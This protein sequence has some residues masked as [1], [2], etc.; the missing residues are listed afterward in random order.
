MTE[1][2]NWTKMRVKHSKSKNQ[3]PILNDMLGIMSYIINR[4]KQEC[5][6][7]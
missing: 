6:R 5:E 4:K 2:E 3:I 1:A 7:L